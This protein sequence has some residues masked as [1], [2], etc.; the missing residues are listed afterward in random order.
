MKEPEAT[1]DRARAAPT[2]ARLWPQS[3]IYAAHYGALGALLTSLAPHLGRVGLS[4]SEIGI[5]LAFSPIFVVVA[6]P[7]WGVLADRLGRSGGLIAAAA[8]ASAVAVL[9]VGVAEGFAAVALAMLAYAAVSAPIASLNDAA[10]LVEVARVGGDYGRVRRW[11]SIGFVVGAFGAGAWLTRV[12][13]GASIVFRL[14]AAGFALAGL[15]ALAIR[16]AAR[17]PEP[18]RPAEALALLRD[19]R[20]RRLL[21]AGGLHW[22]AMAP[23]HGFFAVHAESIGLAPWVPGTGYA[24]GALAEIA[25]MSLAPRWLGPRIGPAMALALGG[26]ALRW[27][28]SGLTT[29]AELLVALQLLHG[30][31]FGLFYLLALRGLASYVPPRL[32]ASGQGVFFSAV[33]GVGGGLGMVAVGPLIEWAGGAVAF[34]A[35]AAVAGLAAWI[36][37]RLP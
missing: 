18:V 27:L 3:A 26:S 12:P 16:G 1:R 29:N 22:F 31:S 9:A 2:E 37:R 8:L 14:T 33:F 11:G 21:L 36:A 25:V 35:A 4:Q 19:P 17:P 7:L 13:D 10:T 32:R 34:F 5:V 24:I 28:L 23:Y 20:L 6:P 15:C 30:L